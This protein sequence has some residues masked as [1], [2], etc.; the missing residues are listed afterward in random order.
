MK[1][2]NKTRKITA[3]IAAMAMTATM[4]IPSVMMSASA[5]DT[6]TIT[7]TAGSGDDLTHSAMA[8]Y[9]IFTG[10]SNA[11]DKLNVTGWGTGV[12]P[13]T[14]YNALK[15]DTTVAIEADATVT[16]AVVQ[17]TVGEL[18]TGLNIASADIGSD[19][20]AVAIAD[21]ISTFGDNSLAAEAVARAVWAAKKTASGTF[22]AATAADNSD[23]DNPVAAVPAKITGLAD[24]YYAVFD[25][26]KATKPSPSNKALVSLNGVDSTM[27]ANETHIDLNSG[28]VPLAGD[29]T[30]NAIVTFASGEIDASI[31]NSKDTKLPST[32]GIGTTLFVL[33]GG[34][35]AGVAGIYLISRKRTKE[36]ETE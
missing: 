29:T 28:F 31:A 26:A 22:V 6:N 18:F 21:V 12:T 35:A 25:T 23:S 13:A 19:A 7:I 8:A 24:G 2:T 33:G 17:K 36:E 5:D 30:K 11:T 34:C 4:A 16:P 10:S 14:F 9:Q 27:T 1:K 3:M 15:A 20:S 32:G